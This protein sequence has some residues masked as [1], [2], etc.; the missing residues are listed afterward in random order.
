MRVASLRTSS[1]GGSY[2]PGAGGSGDS[3]SCRRFARQA[4]RVR[5]EQRQRRVEP[6]DPADVVERQLLDERVLDR[7][8]DVLARAAAE[9]GDEAAEVLEDRG[10]ILG[11]A[12]E[13]R[14]RAEPLDEA[15]LAQQQLGLPAR[16]QPR[17]G[18]AHEREAQPAGGGEDRRPLVLAVGREAVLGPPH[19]HVV[20]GQGGDTSGIAER[21]NASSGSPASAA[22]RHRTVVQPAF[23]TGTNRT[24]CS[25]STTVRSR[26]WRAN[27]GG[28]GA[29]LAARS[30]GVVKIAWPPRG[31]GRILGY[32]A[33]RRDRRSL[34]L[35]A[36]SGRSGTSLFSGILQRLG[37]HV[38]QPEVPA[39]ATN[40]RGFAESQWVVDFHTRQLRAARVQVSD[41]RPAAWALTAQAGLDDAVRA[42]LRAWLAGQ[43]GAAP[44]LIVK[45]PRL[46]W[47]LP[48][49][50]SCAEELG[51]APRFVTMLRHPAAVIDSKQRWYGGWQGD[52]GRTAGW[53]HQTL[54]TERATRGAPR[55][56]VRYE[57]L[58]ED[59]TRI[60]ADVG[61]RL[62]LDVVRDAPA[63]AM[64]D[65]HGFVDRGLSRSRPD[66]GDLA[67][68]RRCAGRPTPYGRWPSGSRTA[69]TRRRPHGSTRCAA[70]T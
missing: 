18:V 23:G 3:F 2:S 67:L 51:V 10:G 65:V 21:S 22:S 53:I 8:V 5:R 7:P 24:R 42:E 50:R 36:G 49:W 47:F 33:A 62:D 60:V 45:D 13:P 1:A 11:Q 25:G 38:P 48:L 35:V 64:R 66:W 54:F 16:P 61:D 58:L 56:F 15:R 26:T 19:A 39:D 68:P 57:D 52:V 27:G 14:R 34:V 40:P 55:A 59:W 44:A 17:G 43:F 29:S 6:L 4:G 32:R 20:H 63:A 28:I 37:C 41:A 30:G 12:R 9:R 31:A 46:S 69:R 70:S